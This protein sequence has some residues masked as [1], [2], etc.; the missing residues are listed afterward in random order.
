MTT[1]GA[2]TAKDFFRFALYGRAEAGKTCYLAALAMDRIANPRNYSTNWLVSPADC[3]R[4]PDEG[5][6]EWLKSHPD[7]ALHHGR[8][9]LEEAIEAIVSN[10]VPKQNDLTSGTLRT[11][12]SSAGPSMPRRT[13]T[14]PTIW[15][16][17]TPL[18]ATIV[19][20]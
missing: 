5:D 7:A 8:I 18:A 9:W 11:G 2:E 16:P 14:S 1:P 6:S 12:L 10:R 13:R 3:P 19:S 17:T 20:N 4:P 15:R